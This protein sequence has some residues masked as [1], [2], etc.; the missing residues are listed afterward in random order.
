MLLTLLCATFLVQLIFAGLVLFLEA[1]EN[2]AGLHQTLNEKL[3]LI[4]LVSSVAGWNVL[5]MEG[6]AVCDRYQAGLSEFA[7][8][9]VSPGQVWKQIQLDGLRFVPT[10]VLYTIPFVV[11]TTWLAPEF[12]IRSGVSVAVALFSCFA[13]RTALCAGSCFFSATNTLQR[14][15]AFSLHGLGLMAGGFFMLWTV[16]IAFAM[17]TEPDSTPAAFAVNVL[18]QQIAT[19]TALGIACGCWH[20]V[21]RPAWSVRAWSRGTVTP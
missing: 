7:R 13:I 1:V 14:W 3:R 20:A 9:P 2:N 15:V 10:Q 17:G 6:F 4:T 18:L 16:G 5:L 21:G 8:R 19:W 11:L 12:M